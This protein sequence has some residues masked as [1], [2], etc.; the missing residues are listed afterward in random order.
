MWI[1]V[2]E[3][4]H[5]A[6][7]RRLT[8]TISLDEWSFVR[9]TRQ[10]K[11]LKLFLVLFL[12]GL[13][14]ACNKQVESPPPVTNVPDQVAL[15]TKPANASPATLSDEFVGQWDA[16]LA[17]PIMERQLDRVVWLGK[18]VGCEGSCELQSVIIKEF[19]LTVGTSFEKLVLMSSNDVTNSCHACSP[20]ISLFRFRKTADGW[21]LSNSDMAFANLGANGSVS[22]DR[23]VQASVKALSESQIALLIDLT[24]AHQGFQETFQFVFVSVDGKFIQAFKEKSG[25]DYSGVNSDIKNAGTVWDSKAA[26]EVNNELKTLVLSSAGKRSGKTFQSVKRY[27]FD[28]KKFIPI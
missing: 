17:N 13:L 10:M 18:N 3:L 20:A 26:I 28:G 2:C 1:S 27:K 5:R 16:N 25:E 19:D 22:G 24:D 21:K 4:D 15:K 12:V 14:T 11:K 8:S 6:A 23:P 9:Y 7:T